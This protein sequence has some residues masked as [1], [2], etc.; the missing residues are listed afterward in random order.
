MKKIYLL[1]AMLLLTYPT[2][3]VLGQTAGP[4]SPSTGSVT[5]S[6]ANFPGIPSGLITAG[7]MSP[8]YADLASYPNCS[9]SFNCYYSQVATVHGFG[10]SIP[11]NAIVT[12]IQL[13]LLK[14]VNQPISDI[15]DS[16]VSLVKGGNSIGNNYGI[17]SQ[18]PQPFAYV[19]YGGPTDLWG[20][21]WTAADINDPLFG[22]QLQMTNGALDQTAQIDHA[23]ITVY[24]TFGSGIQEQFTNDIRLI[25]ADNQ[26]KITNSK[27]ISGL[28]ITV[29]NLLGKKIIDIESYNGQNISL[30]GYPK[31]A[32]LLQIKNKENLITKRFIY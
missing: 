20:T 18:W 30:S 13:D 15:R 10:F 12:G 17:S 31:G 14:M 9:G 19:N 22:F 3:Q 26:L 29:M 23:Q 5:G 1:L 8:A 7:D 32:Y 11:S 21:T 6:G 24:Y 16:V 27:V 25:L 4:N 28:S 2:F